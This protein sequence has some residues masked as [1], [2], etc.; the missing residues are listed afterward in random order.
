VV[1]CFCRCHRE[2]NNFER[3]SSPG[4]NI[5][6]VNSALTRVDDDGILTVRINGSNKVGQESVQESLR[7]NYIGLHS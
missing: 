7:L 1:L 4:S 5:C 2:Q 6:T 3:C